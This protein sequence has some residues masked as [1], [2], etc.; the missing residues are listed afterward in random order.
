ML[1]Q[2]HELPSLVI[3]SEFPYEMTGL[4]WLVMPNMTCIFYQ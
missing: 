4:E 2:Y 3:P 1:N